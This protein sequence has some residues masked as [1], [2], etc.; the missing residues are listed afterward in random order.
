MFALL[1]EMSLLDRREKLAAT[2]SNIARL[3]EEMPSHLLQAPG[4][5]DQA[6]ARFDAVE[7]SI[8]AYDVFGR[9]LPDVE[10]WPE[11]QDHPFTAF[12]VAQ[13]RRIESPH[14]DPTELDTDL[15]EPLPLLWIHSAWL[16][17][18]S[19]GNT[20]AA[21]ALRTGLVKVSNIPHEFRGDGRLA[22]RIAFLCKAVPYE[23]KKQIERN[24]SNQTMGDRK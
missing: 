19:G 13:A 7:A 6:N 24:Q 9:M 12:L 1:A 2:R 11:A 17:C 16:D 10:G 18:L 21:Y 14:V 20:V 3:S 22:E 8:I 4:I 5:F 15:I 23:V